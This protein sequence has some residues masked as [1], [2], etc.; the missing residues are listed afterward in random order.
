MNK[1][2]ILLCAMLGSTFSSHA[3]G[4][5]GKDMHEAMRVGFLTEKLHLNKEEAQ[6]F[7]PLYQQ[8]H[9]EKEKIHKDQKLEKFK[10]KL[11]ASDMTDKETL[12][13][14]DKTMELRQASLDLEK[15]YQAEFLTI[16]SPQKVITLFDVE[17]DLR[18]KMLASQRP[19][20]DRPHRHD[21]QGK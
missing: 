19:N 17:K 8:Y 20:S 14:L 10:G 6:K 4:N 11:Y 9:A 5:P 21:L 3:Q 1:F 16:L 12:A 15:R 13:Y 7:W 2:I 18:M